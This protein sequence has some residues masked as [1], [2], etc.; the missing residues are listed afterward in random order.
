[1]R[2]MQL[3]HDIETGHLGHIQVKN[4]QIDII[5]FNNI[6]D[7]SGFLSHQNMTVPDTGEQ[8]IQQFHINDFVIH[9]K[10]CG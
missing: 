5:V 3:L 10:N 6:K 2:L 9:N 7:F 8:F 1:M 4:N